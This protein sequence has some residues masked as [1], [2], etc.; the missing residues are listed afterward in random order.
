MKRYAGSLVSRL[1][2]A[3]L[4]L[5]PA[6]ILASCALPGDIPG[7]APR[8]ASPQSFAPPERI[9]RITYELGADGDAIDEVSFQELCGIIEARA[10]IMDL[11]LTDLYLSDGHMLAV[12]LYEEDYW[13]GLED[14]LVS[15]GRVEFRDHDGN[16]L[17]D[18]GDILSATN[19]YGPTDD[20]GIS[21]HHVELVFVQ[22]AAGRWR[23]AT[24]AAAGRPAGENYIAI[25]LD[26]ELVSAPV[27]DAAYAETGIDSDSCIVLFGDALP[28]ASTAFAQAVGMALLPLR[29]EHL[30][31]V[32][33]DF[34]Q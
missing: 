1:L 34:G 5:L 30:E 25:Y 2:L 13:D 4:F 28:D 15:A 9:A 7:R 23:E 19:Q 24:K 22:E 21:R 6:L 27:V 32:F 31:T 12:E 14:S 3:A 8:T 20:S 16:V 10:G 18:G 17:L 33:V 11:E 26:D 29:P